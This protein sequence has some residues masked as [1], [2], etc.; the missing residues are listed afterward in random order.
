MTIRRSVLPVFLAAVA[1]IGAACANRSQSGSP[2]NT[3][4]P[5]SRIGE[6]VWQ[7]LMTDDIAKSRAFYEQLLGWRFEQTTRL[8]RPYLIAHLASN[9]TPIAGIAQVARKQPDQPITQWLSYLSVG[10]VDAVSKRLT[11]AGA[12][13]LVAPT[14]IR[15]S[16][17]AVAVDPQGAP[18]GL[19]ELG[20]D[21][22]LP[23]GGQSAEIGTFFWRDYLTKDVDAAR[24]FYTDLAGLGATRQTRQDSLLHYVLTSAGSAP[25]GGVVPV[26][27]REIRPHWL[28][29]IRVNDPA[30]M[31][32]RAEQL[33]GRILL[34]VRADIRNGSV[35]VVADSGGAAIALQKWPF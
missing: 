10:D 35:A 7:D 14:D 21:V 16:R 29:H 17:A 1:A 24:T 20:S 25:V 4:T 22:R 30:A 31:A 13:V 34:P 3:T 15:S 8:G 12:Q 5:A 26:G 11:G 9:S 23:V 28:P 18:I 2:P 32:T 33:G 6:F 19:V 27:E